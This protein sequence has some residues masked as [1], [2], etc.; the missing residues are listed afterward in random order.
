MSDFTLVRVQK[1]LH[2]NDIPLPPQEVTKE[3]ERIDVPILRP[4]HIGEHMAVDEKYINGEFYTLLTNGKTG[5][6]ALMAS[7]T[8]NGLLNQAMRKFEDARFNVKV[9]TRDLASN[10]DW[11]GRENFMNAAQVADKFH[12]LKHAFE[13]LQ[14]LRIYYRQK[15]LTQRREAYEDYKIKKKS[16]P[17]LKFEYTERKLSNKETHR[18]LLARSQYLLYKKRKDWSGSQAERAKLLFTHYPDIE[19]AYELIC[20]F[21]AWYSADQI[22]D[23]DKDKPSKIAALKV[24]NHNLDQWMIEVNKADITEIQNFKSLVERNR[25]CIVNYFITGATNAIAESNNNI[26]QTF[27]RANRG[28]RNL[29]FFYFRLSQ[30]L[31]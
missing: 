11:F 25:G 26:I 4:E 17:E 21:R 14:D 27:M 8:K 12:V 15:L 31:S 20:Q 13:A 1:S 19:V 28:A 6:V 3:K 24:I 29:D 9:L 5:K 7:T 2:E 22:I 16:S 30:F 18:Q 23:Q 10:Y